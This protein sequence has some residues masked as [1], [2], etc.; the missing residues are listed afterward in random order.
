MGPRKKLQ[1]LDSKCGSQTQRES[2]LGSV[3]KKPQKQQWNGLGSIEVLLVYLLFEV[4]EGCHNKLWE[5]KPKALR[6]AV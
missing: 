3:A 2:R 4:E 5:A 1:L 6:N